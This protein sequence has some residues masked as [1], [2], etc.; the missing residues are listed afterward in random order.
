MT[1][2]PPPRTLMHLATLALWLHHTLSRVGAVLPNAARAG[3]GRAPYPFVG[4][5]CRMGVRDT[6]S[7]DPVGREPIQPPTPPRHGGGIS[8][9]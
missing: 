7:V 4:A 2:A 9:A 6:G 1:E 5:G 3:Q 8:A